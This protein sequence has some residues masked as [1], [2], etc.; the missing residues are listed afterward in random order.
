MRID[1]LV[2]NLFSLTD[3][4]AIRFSHRPTSHY[5][6]CTQWR[7]LQDWRNKEE[8][9][10]GKHYA[11]CTTIYKR[12]NFFIFAAIL[13]DVALYCLGV[14]SPETNNKSHKGFCISP[15]ILKQG[16]YIF[17]RLIPQSK[18]INFNSSSLIVLIQKVIQSVASSYQA[19]QLYIN[20]TCVSTP[21]SSSSYMTTS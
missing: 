9:L 1:V 15:T 18:M 13:Y 7:I 20:R 6:M 10:C 16:L 3:F 19:T 21:Q 2:K 14:T 5:R 12:S 8:W 11:T 4:T 17:L